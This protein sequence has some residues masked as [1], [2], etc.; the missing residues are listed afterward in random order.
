MSKPTFNKLYEG[1]ATKPLKKEHLRIIQA[2]IKKTNE[3]KDND[4]C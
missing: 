2:Y 1:G 3:D 4:D